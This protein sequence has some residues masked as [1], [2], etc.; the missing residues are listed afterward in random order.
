MKLN[1]LHQIAKYG[2]E[3]QHLERVDNCELILKLMWQDYNACKSPHQRVMMLEKIAN[4]Q[5]YLSAYYDATREVMKESYF[6]KKYNIPEFETARSD[7]D[8]VV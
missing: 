3:E 5:P 1:Q 2:F 8:N 7:V 4:L 6:M